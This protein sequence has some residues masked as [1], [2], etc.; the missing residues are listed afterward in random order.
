MTAPGTIPIPRSF[1]SIYGSM[2]DAFLSRVGAKTIDVMDPTNFIILAAA[3]SDLRNTSDIFALL[4]ASSLKNAKGLALDRIGA[5]EKYPRRSA[6]YATGSVNFTDTAFQKIFTSVYAGAAAPN[7]GTTTLSVSDA[8]KFPATGQIYIDRGNISVEGPIAYSAKTAVGS[9][10]TLTLSTPTQHFHNVN[11]PVVLAQGGDRPIPAGTVIQTQPGSLA[12]AVNYATTFPATISDG[13]TT[14]T[15]VP[16][17]AQL[18]GNTGNAAAGTITTVVTASI[19]TLT[20]TNPLPF[21]NG[22]NV[23]NDDDYRAALQT[24]LQTRSRGTPLA[25]IFNSLGV[26]STL[27]NKTVVSAAITSIPSEPSTL[28]I[29]DGSGYQELDA[30]IALETIVAK[31]LG[32]EYA[33]SLAAQPPV[34]KAFLETTLQSPFSL[35]AGASLSI[36]IAGMTTTHSFSNDEFFAIGSATA[37]E[38]ASAINSDPALLFSARVTNGGQGVAFFAIAETNEDLQCIPPT[39]GVDANDFLGI[40]A[41]I[42]YTLRL[43]KN[44]TLLYKDGLIASIFSN[45]QSAWSRTMTSGVQIDV[46]ID[47]TP[48]VTY[49]FTDADFI[50]AETGYSILSATNSLASWAAVWN[51]KVPGLTATVSGG[52]LLFT[53]NLGTSSRAA[54]VFSEPIG[55]VNNLIQLGVLSSTSLESVGLP[56]D[57]ALNRNTGKI[58]LFTPLQAGEILT[59]GTQSQ[60]AYTQ[61]SAH[62]TATVTLSTPGTL[63][64]SVDGAA[65]VLTTGLNGGSVITTNS[66]LGSNRVRYTVTDT[67]VFGSTSGMDIQPGDW[68]ISYDTNLSVIGA[69]RISDVLTSSPWNWFEV[70]RPGGGDQVS[71]TPSSNG[72]VFARSNSPLQTVRLASGTNQSLDSVVASITSQLQGAQASVYR[73]QNIRITTN[74]YDIFGDINVVA[75]DLSGQALGFTAGKLVSNSANRVATV[76]SQNTD[77]GAS[78]KSVFNL[79]SQTG[80]SSFTTA[81]GLSSGNLVYWSRRRPGTSWG[82]FGNTVDILESAIVNGT[83]VTVEDPVATYSLPIGG[84]VRSGTT[85]TGTT[86]VTHNLRVGDFAYIWPVG[87]A[88]S[89]FAAG[90]KLI[91][92]VPASNQFTYTET[93]SAVASIH[94]YSASLNQGHLVND[95]F[96]SVY[97]FSIAAGD[98]L[99]VVLDGDDVNKNYSLPLWRELAPTGGA[100]YSGSGFGIV[101]VDNG[102]LPPSSAFGSTIPDLF[103]DMAL[104]QNARGKSHAAGGSSANKALLWRWLRMGPEGNVVTIAY[105]NPTAP[106]QSLGYAVANG[107]D[108]G[109]VSSHF[110]INLPSGTARTGIGLLSTT[111]WTVSITA[112]SPGEIVTYSYSKPTIAIGGLTRSGS[113]V[114]AV[115]GSNHGFNPG[116]IVY[117]SGS[118]D[119]NYT[120]GPKNVATTP[121]G[122]TFTYIESGTGTAS[123]STAAV[124][125][126]A[127]D[128]TLTSSVIVGDI[129]T[130]ASTAGFPVNDTGTFR[131]TAVTGSTFSV[132]VPNLAATAVTTPVSQFS[133]SAIT[134]FPITSQTASQIAAWANANT[135]SLVSAVAVENG[136]GTPGTGNITIATEDEWLQNITNS[137]TGSV[138]YWPLFDG[139]NWIKSSD[140]GSLPNTITLKNSV[141]SDLT[142]NADFANE[143]FHLVPQKADSLATW[144]SNP[145][146]SGFYAGAEILA[147]SKAHRLQLAS[148]TAGSPGSIEVVGGTAD[149]TGASLVGSGSI[150]SGGWSTV[151]IDSTQSPG[152]VANS[153]IALQAGITQTK[154]SPWI[155]TS[156]LNIGNGGLVTITGSTEVWTLREELNTV[157]DQWLIRK[158]GNFV[159]YTLIPVGGNDLNEVQET[160]WAVITL[161][162]AS[163]ANTGTFKVVGRNFADKTFWVEN[164]NAVSELVT[165]VGS[166][167]VSFFSYDSVMPGDTFT[168]DTTVFGDQVAG[169]YTILSHGMATSQFFVTPSPALVSTTVMGSA[170]S[171]IRVVEASPMRLI[172][173]INAIAPNADSISLTDILF[174]S[175]FS[176]SKVGSS[177]GSVIQA[178]DKLSFPTT[179]ASGSDAYTVATG[180]IGETNRVL[181]GDLS[182]PDVYPGVI[183]EGA[184]INIEGALIKRIQVAL[185]IRITDGVITE[186][187]AISLVQN[188]VAALINSL[189]TGQSVSLS[190]VV[191]AAAAV[192]GVSAVSVVSPTYSST[193]DIIVVLQRE[194]PRVLN[195]SQDIQVEVIG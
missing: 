158:I 60:R 92:T 41:G 85:V 195:L 179:I 163:A 19:P 76:E 81:T 52:Q 86:T 74:S 12:A 2:I 32:G 6:T 189:K 62:T 30:G 109:A 104:Y 111:H 174:T 72:F 20:T 35:V 42:S 38:V 8:S 183:A 51:L 28:Y 89:N 177:T 110:S 7:A 87:T 80:V 61:S 121:T 54:I 96:F 4:A 191:S 152:F 143:K 13:E 112:D 122:T 146:I 94:A 91:D 131:V 135:D 14:I 66:T 79:A 148:L 145:A 128:P 77:I 56:K 132:K 69:W 140:L 130:I 129:V 106:S 108:T 24:L 171:F 178:L 138:P 115:T 116:D 182:N 153:F 120:N 169:S 63:W 193:N 170:F 119:G 11:T 181:Y 190:A 144:L 25:I 114:T 176:I 36:Q 105:S 10:W 49:T 97:P 37:D 160:D 46:A 15:S 26:T 103:V 162:G 154:R 184:N 90:Y 73:N 34:T 71:V 126:A 157:G 141:A 9:Y 192:A 67:D 133:A 172:K 18:P 165:D 31:A 82:T 21:S 150:T 93:G 155:I 99:S 185:A 33:F 55:V 156:S 159:A 64:V 43:Y 149:S 29:D 27:E 186:S 95:Q 68:F 100:I 101:D 48:A 180:L 147:A 166:D 5:D 98:T 57:Y 187:Q 125:A 173:Q 175:S 45:V 127:S 124:S 40:P 168:I 137:S 84:L 58:K 164:P 78:I 59:A 134:F 75:V 83:A 161:S 167:I 136:G 139:I 1:Q 16:V 142:S 107:Q 123:L 50:A 194:K 65:K 53:S 17:T 88:D 102:D 23:Q 117:I 151:T 113:T 39:S 44:D 3:Q 70:E 22:F 47:N 188:A 118:S